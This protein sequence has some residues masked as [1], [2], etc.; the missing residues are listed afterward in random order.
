MPK[1]RERYTRGLA[2]VLALALVALTFTSGRVSAQAN[3]GCLLRPGTCGHIPCPSGG[4][5]LSL[6]TTDC[7]SP[8]GP[9]G[10]PFVS[11]CYLQPGT[12]CQ[13]LDMTGADLTGAPLTAANLS[14]ANLTTARVAGANLVT[15]DLHGANLTVANLHGAD[16][17][18]ANLSGANLLGADLSGADLVS[19][20]LR[21]VL[22]NSTNFTG[23][24]LVGADMTGVDLSGF[25][26]DWTSATCPDGSQSTG[27]VN[28]CKA[29]RAVGVP[30]VPA[31]HVTARAGAAFD[32]E[33][34][35]EVTE[36]LVWRDLDQAQ[37]ILYDVS[38][39]SDAFVVTLQE[40]DGSDSTLEANA[41]NLVSLNGQ[42]SRIE[43]SG[44]TGRTV[45]LVLNLTFS[46][47]AASKTFMLNIGV[48]TD[49]GAVQEMGA[50][51][52]ISVGL[53]SS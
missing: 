17:I 22:L 6:A 10:P 28:G 1:S 29:A 3:F 36:P 7:P 46:S 12:Q 31:P 19:A 38:G 27:R 24:V 15:A 30:R 9:D 34:G 43:G 47:E 51:G 37:I 25:D 2:H 13:G 20:N 4:Q 39:G 45:R 40:R 48:R 18:A 44:P 8:R 5:V 14:G 16:L 21:N 11:G 49:G 33:V 32:Y 42:T 26:A 53:P 23:A 35:W 52:T 50:L 41:S